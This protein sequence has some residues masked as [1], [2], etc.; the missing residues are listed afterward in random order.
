MVPQDI[1]NGNEEDQG[2]SIFT[3][4]SGAPTSLGG[5]YTSLSGAVRRAKIPKSLGF[6][7][8]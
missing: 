8:N 3:S 5:A 2:S 7:K 1:V 6:A 4:L